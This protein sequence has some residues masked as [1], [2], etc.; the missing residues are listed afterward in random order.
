M[1]QYVLAGPVHFD[2]R[3]TTKLQSKAVAACPIRT[4][5]LKWL[6][7]NV[8]EQSRALNILVDRC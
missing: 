7:L 3:S 8:L 4:H 2:R 6:G 5:R 1:A